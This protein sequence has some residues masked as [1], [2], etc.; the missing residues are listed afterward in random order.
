MISKNKPLV[1]MIFS[2]SILLLLLTFLTR[3]LGFLREVLIAYF[4]GTSKIVD[5]YVSSQTVGELLGNVI[6]VGAFS[7]YTVMMLSKSE[8]YFKKILSIALL[9]SVGFWILIN[10]NEDFLASLLQFDLTQE[11]MPLLRKFIFYVSPTIVLLSVGSVFN[12]YL[13]Y[14]ERYLQPVIAIVVMNISFIVFFIILQPVFDE[15]VLPICYLLSNIIYFLY[16]VF[17]YI[18]LR[19]DTQQTSVTVEEKNLLEIFTGV[20]PIVLTLFVNKITLITDRVFGGYLPDGHLAALNF[21]FK[22]INLPVAIIATSLVNIMFVKYTTKKAQQPKYLKEYT[23]LLAGLSIVTMFFMFF[24]SSEIVK[25]VYGYGQFDQNSIYVTSS[26][27]K[28]YSLTLP[29]FFVLMLFNKINYINLSNKKILAVSIWGI[30]TNIGLNIVLV[31]LIG[32]QGIAISTIFSL[33]LQVVWFF[34]L[35]KKAIGMNFVLNVPVLLRKVAFYG[36][37]FNFT[38]IL[39]KIFNGTLVQLIIAVVIYIFMTV[40]LMALFK[41]NLLVK[42]VRLNE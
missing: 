6:L 21:A 18:L 10:I 4:Y 3:V 28:V 25:S 16:S 33:L 27:L 41:Y 40:S 26:I 9:V 22:L 14:K 39:H 32:V 24:Y 35:T 29:M 38:Y 31:P 36:M 1:K 20:F 37:L 30:L 19:K 2:T 23:E 42:V 5:F 15:L 11:S 17:V 13:Q 34:L 7:T 12:G 8:I